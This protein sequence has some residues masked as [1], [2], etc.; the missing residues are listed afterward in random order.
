MNIKL[1][2]IAFTLIVA[3]SFILSNTISAELSASKLAQIENSVNSMSVNQLND[4]MASLQNE[5]LM[6]EAEQGSSQNP[7]V[8]KN[9]L[10]RLAEVN[11]ELSSVQRALALVVGVGA[12]SSLSSDDYDDN[13]PPVITI[14]GDNPA[15]VELGA[16]YSDS[17]ASA[18]DANHGQH[19]LIIWH[20]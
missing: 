3:S 11:A 19:L 12:I 17:G 10:E 1:K 14:N 16:S 9:I 20:S 4:R 7:S 6:L 8:N 15:T 5:K 18:F 13:I 2:N